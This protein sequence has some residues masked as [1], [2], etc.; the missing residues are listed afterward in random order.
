MF[1]ISA[2]I[3]GGCIVDLSA[4]FFLSPPAKLSVRINNTKMTVTRTRPVGL[5]V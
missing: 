2:K 1:V 3:V 5:G 4:D